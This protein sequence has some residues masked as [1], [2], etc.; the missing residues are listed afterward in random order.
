MKF[1]A[2]TVADTYSYHDVELETT[3]DPYE[4]SELKVLSNLSSR[5]KSVAFRRI[6]MELLIDNGYKV[7]QTKDPEVSLIVNGKRVCI[8][9]S[10]GWNTDGVITHYRFQQIKDQ[11]Y[12]VLLFAFFTPDEL[13]LKGNTKSVILDLLSR[14]NVA[15]EYIHNQ[16]GGKTVDSG[17]YFVDTNPEF[18]TWLLDIEDVLC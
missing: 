5:K 16:H 2:A 3:I 8:K 18:D 7:L 1:T 14:K 10:M 12:D 4:K 11:E 9:G 13:I 15:G 6:I 17:T